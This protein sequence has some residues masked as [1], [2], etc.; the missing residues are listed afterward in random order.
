LNF[1][2]EADLAHQAVYHVYPK[3][4]YS[5]EKLIDDASSIM[6]KNVVSNLTDG[7]RFDINQAGK[8][9]AFEVPTAAAFHIFR[10]LDS[11]LR[12]YVSALGA[13]NF[14]QNWGSYIKAAIDNGGEEKVVA[15]LR[16]LKDLH[17]NPIIHPEISLDIE[18]GL[19]LLGI[20]ES[21]ISLMI[22][23]IAGRKDLVMS[24]GAKERE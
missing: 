23:D 22:G 2:L 1:V 10:A 7:E 3:R 6:S 4:A 21:A 8:C 13:E 20:A 11:I 12:R 15:V 5:T 14:Q 18:S 19:S 9:L 16:Q 24:S 17:R